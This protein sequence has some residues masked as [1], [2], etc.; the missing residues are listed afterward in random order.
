MHKGL[1]KQQ[2]ILSMN[3]SHKILLYCIIVFSIL[4][5]GCKKEET[6]KL[7]FVTTRIVESVRRTS[8]WVSGSASLPETDTI[9]AIG[10]CWNTKSTPTLHDNFTYEG[11]WLND[12]S[13][14]IQGLAPNTTY[15]LR[16]YVSCLK[17]VYY[18]NERIFT[19]MQASSGIRFNSGLTYGTVSDIEGNIYK[20]IVIG[21]QTWMAEN[22]RATKYNDNSEIPLVTD[23]G[24][25]RHL[26]APGYCWYENN[27][28]IYKNLYGAYYNWYAV[29][30]GKLCPAG[31]HVSSDQEWKT[32]EMYLGMAQG[33][34]DFWYDRG[35]NEGERLKESGTDNWVSDGYTGTNDTG[36]TGLPSGTRKPYDEDFTG[37]GYVGYWWTSTGGDYSWAI[38]HGLWSYNSKVWRNTYEKIAGCN[39]RCI[40]D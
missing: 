19:T 6:E 33:P 34:A 21:T 12:F 28:D 40:K 5:N 14:F 26:T 25:W 4:F 36:F 17:G 31:W 7:P 11:A 1:A 10:F 29:K 27:A 15:Y 23:V 13:S 18:G 39:V 22:L 32:L 20:T 30:T 24:E 8:A 16:A 2:N 3:Y 35:T 9:I 37:E 38:H